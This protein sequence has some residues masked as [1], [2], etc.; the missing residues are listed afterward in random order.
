M[1]DITK[2]ALKR[3]WEESKETYGWVDTRFL[4]VAN[5]PEEAEMMAIYIAGLLG[6]SELED[7]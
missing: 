4:M 5:S 3:F 1:S 2:N 7:G 6:G